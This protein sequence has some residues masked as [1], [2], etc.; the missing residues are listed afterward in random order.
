M[1]RAI[2]SDNPVFHLTL[3]H[4]HCDVNNRDM[5]TGR[6]TDEITLIP[7]DVTN[8][9]AHEEQHDELAA[10]ISARQAAGDDP[11]LDYTLAKAWYRHHP[12]NL[13]KDTR[14]SDEVGG[15]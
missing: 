13:E 4:P 1:C 9:F 5:W 2:A 11:L 6:Q 12:E 7:F 3:D 8:F 14:S 15:W 10:Q